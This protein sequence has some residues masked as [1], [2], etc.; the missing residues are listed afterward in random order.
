[1]D[2]TSIFT[3]P[4]AM[5]IDMELHKAD[6]T[7][8]LD[9]LGYKRFPSMSFEKKGMIFTNTDGIHD[10]YMITSHSHPR[11]YDGHKRLH[12]KE[13]NVDLFLALAA[14]NDSDKLR[15]GEYFVVEVNNYYDPP[16]MKPLTACNDVGYCIGGVY[17]VNATKGPY[18]YDDSQYWVEAKGMGGITSGNIR[19]A[20][21]KE[22]IRHFCENTI[23]PCED[24]EYLE[25]FN[26]IHRSYNK[27]R[28]T[29]EEMDKIIDI[30][31]NI[32]GIEP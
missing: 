15:V 19:K 17:K 31:I 13:T 7:T 26:F 18:I 3:Q 32:K 6:I 2:K 14:M 22:I 28:P 10:H 8:G 5:D 1:M 4:V 23:I 12:I 29:K 20:T 11:F 16:F 25:L 9:S 27:V 21:T 30:C 24:V